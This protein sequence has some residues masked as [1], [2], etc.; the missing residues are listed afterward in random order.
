MQGIPNRKD[1]VPNTLNEHL[2]N[3]SSMADLLDILFLFLFLLILFLVSLHIDH[4][5]FVPLLSEA[6]HLQPSVL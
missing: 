2:L 1:I 4:P 6:H 3:E 5:L